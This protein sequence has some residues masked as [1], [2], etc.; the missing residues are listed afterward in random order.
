MK[1]A[2]IGASGFVGSALLKE[3]L[4]RGH[5]VTAIVRNP[6]K[7]STV[8]TNLSVVK[9]DVMNGEDLVPALRD[10]DIVISAFNPGWANPNIY[11]EYLKGA[12]SIQKAVEQLKIRF[13]VVGGAGSLYIAPNLQLIDTPEFPKEIKEGAKAAR[14]YLEIIKKEKDLNWTYFSPAIEMAPENLGERTGTYR[15]GLE[16]PVFDENGRSTISVEDAAVAIIDEA[17]VP[18]HIRQRFTVAY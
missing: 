16:N 14:E 7:I 6:E 5:N 11:K 12:L 9:A 1:I 17:E 3:A 4:D 2:L 15:T 8:N 18:T 10:H 13:L